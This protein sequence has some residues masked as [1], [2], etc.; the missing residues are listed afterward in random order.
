MILENLS[1]TNINIA[2]TSIKL[3]ALRWLVLGF[4]K[5]RFQ[6]ASKA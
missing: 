4:Y 5:L 2:L 1:V 3:Q 6:K